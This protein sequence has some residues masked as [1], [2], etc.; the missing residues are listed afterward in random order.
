LL[1]QAG[2]ASAV[3]HRTQGALTA[4]RCIGTLGPWDLDE[5]VPILKE[6]RHGE[7]D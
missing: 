2:G 4:L 1:L 7:H 3:A 6:A 5:L